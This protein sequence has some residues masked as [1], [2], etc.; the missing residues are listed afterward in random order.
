MQYEQGQLIRTVLLVASA[1]A[2]GV[3]ATYS[4]ANNGALLQFITDLQSGG[5]GSVGFL[6]DE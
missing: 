1:I 2:T 5:T 6:K 4:V 3:L